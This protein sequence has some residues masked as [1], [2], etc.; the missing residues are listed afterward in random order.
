MRQL[1][2]TRP[3]KNPNVNKYQRY[4]QSYQF[5]EHTPQRKEYMTEYNKAYRE[6][7]AEYIDCDCGSTIKGTSFYAHVKSQK[8]LAY[9]SS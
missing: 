1:D 5:Y 6:Q 9:L 7:H 8:H 3:K 2:F 4:I